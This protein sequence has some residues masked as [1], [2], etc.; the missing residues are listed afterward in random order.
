MSGLC[1]QGTCW[2]TILVKVASSRFS[3]RPYL[4]VRWT[5]IEETPTVCLPLYVQV[6]THIHKCTQIHTHRHYTYM[7]THKTNKPK[8]Q[9]KIKNS[10]QF[11]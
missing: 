8:P 5:V 7:L 11:Y 4:K 10:M 2:L 6:H 1:I 9:K 3:E